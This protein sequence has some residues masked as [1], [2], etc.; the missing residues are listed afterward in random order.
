MKE[1]TRGDEK[2]SVGIEKMMEREKKRG[3]QYGQV[4]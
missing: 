2:R 3:M 4:N 1:E